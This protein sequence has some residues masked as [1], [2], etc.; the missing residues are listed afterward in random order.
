MHYEFNVTKL[1]N[2]RTQ[3]VYNFMSKQKSNNQLVDNRNIRNSTNIPRCEKFKH[4]IFYCGAR[5]WNQLPVKERM[6]AGYSE[7]KNVQKT[8]AFL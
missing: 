3:H 5:L 4:N 2:R 1:D 7:F 8:K 6:I